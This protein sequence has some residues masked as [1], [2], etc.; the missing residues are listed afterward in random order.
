MKKTLLLAIAAVLMML[1]LYSILECG[2]GLRAW[3]WG[4]F[5]FMGR[6]WSADKAMM[7]AVWPIVVLVSL[8]W[9]GLLSVASVVVIRYAIALRRNQGSVVLILA[10]LI[11]LV[12]WMYWVFGGRL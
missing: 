4:P 8:A 9:V 5:D 12:S 6:A 11:A 2:L 7:G 3:I 10:A 1:D